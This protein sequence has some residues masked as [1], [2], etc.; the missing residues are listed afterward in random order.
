MRQNGEG[1]D[2]GEIIGEKEPRYVPK[3][4]TGAV[5]LSDGILKSVRSS[6]PWSPSGNT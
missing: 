1:V 2:A 5:G 6:N 3:N 4:R